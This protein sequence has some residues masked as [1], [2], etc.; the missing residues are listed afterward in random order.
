MITPTPR[1]LLTTPG[2]P[3]EL[4][5][6]PPWPWQYEQTRRDDAILRHAILDQRHEQH[7]SN[8]LR[9]MWGDT[10]RAAV[11][12]IDM[13]ANPLATVAQQLSTPG[14]YGI[15][16]TIRHPDPAAEP[17]IGPGGLLDRA[18]W[19]ATLKEVEF[20]ARGMGCV[21]VYPTFPPRS[22]GDPEDPG[23]APIALEIIFPYCL[24]V[25]CPP[26]QPRRVTRLYDL[27]IHFLDG[28][29]TY[30][31]DIWDIN[32]P[33]KPTH[34]VI[35]GDPTQPST[36][37]DRTKEIYNQD[38]SGDA[39]PWRYANGRPYIP[40]TFYRA[41][42]RSFWATEQTQALAGAVPHA[43]RL[44]NSSLYAADFASFGWVAA[45]GLTPRSA[46]VTQQANGN[47]V[48]SLDLAPGAVVPFDYDTN[49]RP[50]LLQQIQPGARPTEMLLAA[51]SY[52]E[53]AMATAGIGGGQATRTEGNPTSA[54]ALVINDEQRRAAQ[55]Q[56]A[57]NALNSDRVLLA[58]LAALTTA[59]GLGA[60]PESGYTIEYHLIPQTPQEAADD[61]AQAEF[62]R[63]QKLISRIQ[64]Y[65][66]VHPGCDRAAAIAALRQADEDDALLDSEADDAEDPIDNNSQAEDSP[67]A[68]PTPE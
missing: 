8:F 6:P 66:R 17:L 42:E 11:G 26:R 25:E 30:A 68:V 58:K 10:K 57:P 59:H 7:V 50:G 47:P 4:L 46:T 34:H 48:S 23:E 55:R 18:Q 60:P 53:S 9:T 13:T 62:E 63:K 67:E 45:I 20:Y 22:P 19:Q 29:H 2:N 44:A 5:T 12:Q 41:N 54:A 14:L 1:T 39:Y 33:Q 32:D 21:A 37:R 40:H 31:W 61:R 49:D 35:T 15:T 65:Q 38:M 16:P 28:R 56:W 43:V 64:L 51:Q 52:N 3:Y 27:T 24:H 36:A